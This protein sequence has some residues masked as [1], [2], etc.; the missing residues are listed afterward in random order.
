MNKILQTL[1]IAAV[2]LMAI[3]FNAC[4][5]EDDPTQDIS[6][7]PRD[8]TYLQNQVQVYVDGDLQTSVTEITVHSKPVD[9]YLMDDIYFPQYD[10]TLKIKGLPKKGKTTNITVRAGIDDFEGSTEIN[11]TNYSVTGQFTGDP[12]THYSKQGIIVYLTRR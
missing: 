8:W 5:D 12:L 9:G 6:G 10:S 1:R 7:S 11:G 2:C 3:S 4:I